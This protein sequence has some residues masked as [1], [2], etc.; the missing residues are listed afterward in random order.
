MLQYLFSVARSDKRGNGVGRDFALGL[1]LGEG[2][3]LTI[4]LDGPV[5]NV[6]K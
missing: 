5:C 1:T 6:D 4:P 2:A 3:P